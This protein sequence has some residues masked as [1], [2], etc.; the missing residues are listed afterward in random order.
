MSGPL[1]MRRDLTRPFPEPVW[2]DGIVLV[3]FSETMA[4]E[5]HAVMLDGYAPNGHAVPPYADWRARLLSDPEYDAELI[6][7]AQA[8]DGGLVGLAH[9][10]NSGFLKDLVVAPD[11]RRRGIGEAL[12]L[13]SFEACRNRYHPHLDLKVDR[14]N[15]SA[16]RFYKKRGMVPL[17]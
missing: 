8:A 2:P 9:C 7:V 1:R 10:W 12:L 6:F 15:E 16:I 14:A 17:Q 13:R 4:E 3:P 5:L 11:W